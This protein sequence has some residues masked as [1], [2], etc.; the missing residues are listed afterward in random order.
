MNARERLQAMIRTNRGSMTVWSPAEVTDA[1][2][3]HRDESIRDAA[4][5]CAVCDT[6]IGWINSPTGDWW[7]HAT[8]P[9]D[10]HDAQPPGVLTRTDILAE[11]LDAINDAD[12][13]KATAYRTNR[14]TGLGWETARDIVR[15]ML[16]TA[17]CQRCHGT[18]IDPDHSTPGTFHGDYPEPPAMEPCMACQAPTAVVRFDEHHA[19]HL[20]QWSA[21]TF[22]KDF[23]V[24]GVVEPGPHWPTVGPDVRI[25]RLDLPGRGALGG[26]TA[27]VG[28][29][30]TGPDIN[31]T[32]G[33]PTNL[34]DAE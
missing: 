12:L 17:Q 14:G 23:I 13:R 31:L 30:S 22:G 10:G 27:R 2:N 32:I 7:A 20:H 26:I 19:V 3:A 18:G 4:P 15:N 28:L 9:K 34:L 25:R 24:T 21:T 8:H 5:L 11:V 16:T 33:F 29:S 1:L 6:P